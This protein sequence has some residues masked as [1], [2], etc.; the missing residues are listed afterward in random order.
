MGLDGR[1]LNRPNSRSKVWIFFKHVLYLL[2]ATTDQ[3][4]L[5]DFFPQGG[6]RLVAEVYALLSA[7]SLVLCLF[8]ARDGKWLD[9]RNTSRACVALV[10][11]QLRLH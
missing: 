10:T 1:H 7:F 8:N 4:Y 3:W 9:V 11:L 2:S 5:K 6:F